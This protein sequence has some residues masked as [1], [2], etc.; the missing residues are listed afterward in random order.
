MTLENMISKTAL[1]KLRR[2]RVHIG[3]LGPMAQSVIHQHTR[4]HRFRD[5]RG[6]QAHAGI[7]AAS[8]LH[9]GRFAV[10]VDGTARYADGRRRLEAR[11]QEPG[12]GLRFST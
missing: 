2:R 5:R 9:C 10:D 11:I 3:A 4:Q 7:V 6:A 1:A 12:R 8:G